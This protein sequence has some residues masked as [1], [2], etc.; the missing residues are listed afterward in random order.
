MRAALIFMISSHLPPS[1]A[2][3]VAK[4]DG[5]DADEDAQGG[6]SEDV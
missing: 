5:A 3:F 4:A 2:N 1:L 6:A